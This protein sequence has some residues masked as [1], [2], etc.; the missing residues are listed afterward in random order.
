MDERQRFVNAAKSEYEKYLTLAAQAD[1]QRSRF[2]DSLGSEMLK[3]RD[4]DP[5]HDAYA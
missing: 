2:E 3:W 5:T 1:D 4:A